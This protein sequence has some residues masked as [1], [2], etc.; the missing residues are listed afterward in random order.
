M[1]VMGLHST[2][3]ALLVSWDLWLVAWARSHAE[4][5][6]YGVMLTI[7]QAMT[8]V[9]A[10][11]NRIIPQEFSVLHRE[12]RWGELESLVRGSATAIGIVSC[13]MLLGLVL[14]GRPL[15]GLAFGPT[16]VTGWLVLVVLAA[17]RCF[18]ALCGSAGFLL[19]MTGHHR[20]L[21][22]VT[23]AGAAANPFLA[24]LL[25]PRFGGIGVAVATT[26]SLVGLNL[27][28]VWLARRRVGIRSFAY[29]S[30]ERWA[31]VA[32]RISGRTPA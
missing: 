15:I 10:V 9:P 1:G 4:V 31:A 6:V 27:T 22:A 11:A 16:Y 13:L 21:L 5:A 25:G 20:E 26:V 32:R 30:L 19:Q 18:D 8:V 17:G 29:L 14:L 2:F 3:A 28:L 24:V 23:A 12:A 7:V